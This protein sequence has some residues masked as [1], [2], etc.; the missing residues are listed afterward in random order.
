MSP[1]AKHA[2]RIRLYRRLRLPLAA[3]SA[4]GLFA[5]LL[6][7]ALVT[8]ADVPDR[9]VA[10]VAMVE[11]GATWRDT[12]DIKGKWTHGDA[13][14]I[15][16]WQITGAVLEDLGLSAA[17]KRKIASDTVYAESVFRLWYSGLLR[18]TGSHAEALAAYHRGLGGRTRRDARDYAARVL[19][20]ASVL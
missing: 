11:T 17:Q 2:L 18:K 16:H 20:L 1:H 7:G 8:A 12:G 19:A 4:I 5:L 6:I 9:I 10:A 13:G 14:E 3:F 15:S